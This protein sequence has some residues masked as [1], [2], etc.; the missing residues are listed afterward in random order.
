MRPY[1]SGAPAPRF[2]VL[3][4]KVPT[5]CI[6]V[7]STTFGDVVCRGCRR[8]LHEVVDWNRYGDEAKRLVW[9]RLEALLAQVLPAYFRIEDPALLLSQMRHQHMDTRYPAPWSL[10]YALLRAGARQD[11][12][13]ELF[14]VCRLDRSPR[15]LPQL[16]EHI[17][18]E[19]YQLA[20]AYYEKDHLR[21]LARQASLPTPP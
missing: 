15:S 21:A 13:R 17:N 2:S 11:P 20:C 14:G 10:L 19:L 16:R 7:C 1:Y 18:A 4:D 9:Q 3:F 6:G 8:Y 5:P 12:P